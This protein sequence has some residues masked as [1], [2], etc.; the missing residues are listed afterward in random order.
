MLTPTQAKQQAIQTHHRNQLANELHE[1][2]DYIQANPEVI[3]P[4][5]RI[6][7]R[8]ESGDITRQELRDHAFFLDA[9]LEEHPAHAT[10]LW[11]RARLTYR[12]QTWGR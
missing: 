11:T 6:T 4:G 1:L 7:I 9:D 3:I 10:C 12:L 8:E 5:N 2:A